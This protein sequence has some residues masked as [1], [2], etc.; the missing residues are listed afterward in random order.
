M[1]T[2]R[3]LSKIRW[4]TV[5][6]LAVAVTTAPAAAVTPKFESGFNP[7]GLENIGSW[8][9]PATADL[10]NDGD[11][12]VLI[13]ASDGN[14]TY[15]ENV[16]TA[17]A[18]EYAAPLSNPFGLS[19]V[20]SNAHP[21]FVDIDADG[22][23][24]LFVGTNAGPLEF[25]E[26][27]GTF[28]A[29]AFAA[30][31]SNPFS[32]GFGGVITAP[33]FGDVD[34]DADY[35]L[36][37][38]DNGGDFRF[39]ENVGTKV[40]P[41]FGGL[42]LNPF[43]LTS[44][45]SSSAPQWVDLDGDND[46]DVV[47]GSGSADIR[48]YENVGTLLA[49]SYA[50]P[51]VNPVG[52]VDIGNRTS[53]AFEDLDDDNV[54]D[55]LVGNGEGDTALFLNVGNKFSPSMVGPSLDAL[56]L[57]P[58]TTH[59]TLTRGD[60]D[61]DGD[62]DVLMGG[63]SGHLRYFENTGSPSSPSFAAPVV[64][65]FGLPYFASFIPNPAAGD[66]D[67][68]GDLDVMVGDDSGTMVFFENVGT[69]V[70]PSFAAGVYHPFGIGAVSAYAAPDLA[71]LD[72]DGDL[73]VMVGTG[74]IA[75]APGN[76]VF[77]ENVG[78]P[79]APSFAS[80][81]TNPFGLVPLGGTDSVPAMADVDGDGDLDLFAGRGDGDTEYFENVGSPF[82][83]AFAPSVLNPFGIVSVLG[84]AAPAFAD[85]DADGDLDGIWGASWGITLFF[86]NV[87]FECPAS[88]APTCTTGFEKGQ[89]QINAKKPGS[90]KLLAKLLKGPAATQTDLGN[91]TAPGGTQTALCVYRDTGALA[92]ELLVQRGG[93]L[94]AGKPC[95]K[96]IGGPP[97]SGK[98]YV[99]KD[100]D[101]S[102][103]GVSKIVAKTG[104]VGKTK[105]ILKAGNNA[106]KLQA[107]LP[108]D[109]ITSL[110]NTTSVDV[111]YIDSDGG[112][113]GTTLTEITK[114]G[115]IFFRAK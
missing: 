79:T 63:G 4:T 72:G 18:P 93:Q 74:T 65:P 73:D 8:A 81:V 104:D 53:L 3:I 15:L 59:V 92:A 21:V 10:D 94:C 52:F 89:L 50:A 91:P 67:G 20:G 13:G 60:F 1:N 71:D 96:S 39:V 102:S 106:K 103:R 5:V 31:V 11:P 66:L 44:V 33:T 68:D 69:A 23:F 70:A 87:A 107:S 32:I 46:L 110:G 24:D 27:V 85:L 7:L 98:G 58:G 29:P 64:S 41:S 22:D 77:Y 30:P 109:I 35:D 86:E 105:V 56:G 17:A 90:E 80:G 14:L 2:K 28:V 76:N 25:F 48:I 75:F 99:Y 12:D 114:I 6:G 37:I 47:S 115:D 100:K 88:P 45:S 54:L 55:A 26:N 83:P 16:G 9:A 95:W 34:A 62:V 108:T 36:L 42:V 101:A 112:C 78:T 57:A 19:D 38:G 43:G 113:L 51:L 49:P 82:A 97:P 40:A 61:A 84:S 111:Q